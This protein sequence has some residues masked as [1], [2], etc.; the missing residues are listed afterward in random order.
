MGTTPSAPSS[1]SFLIIALPFIVLAL[2]VALE[3]LLLLLLVPFF[4]LGRVIF[5]AHWTIEARRGFTIWWDAPAGTWRE[6]GERIVAIAHE[7]E[8]GEL[9]PRTVH[10][11][12]T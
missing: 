5:G 10:P 12:A 1:P 2:V 6:S 9:P 11:E 8:R 3:F 7:I 4:A